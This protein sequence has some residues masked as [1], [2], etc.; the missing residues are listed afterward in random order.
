VATKFG[1]TVLHPSG[2]GLER[3]FACPFLELCCLIL[4]LL[5]S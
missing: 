1:G 5:F 4:V 2:H 3:G